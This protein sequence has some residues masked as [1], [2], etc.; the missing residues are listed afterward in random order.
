MLKSGGSRTKRCKG[1]GEV[2]P[3]LYK[4][5]EQEKH[6]VKYKLLTEKT[7]LGKSKNTN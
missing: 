5:Y 1:K 6:R 4:T 2:I 7:K 3:I